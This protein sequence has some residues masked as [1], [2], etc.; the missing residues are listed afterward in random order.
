MWRCYLGL[1][2]V[3]IVKWC[4]ARLLSGTVN[5]TYGLELRSLKYVPVDDLSGRVE[6]Y[7]TRRRRWTSSLHSRYSIVTLKYSSSRFSYGK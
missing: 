4:V 6:E 3:T 7:K 2:S 1:D 5:Q